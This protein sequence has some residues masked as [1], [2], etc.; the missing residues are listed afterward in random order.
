MISWF[1]SAQLV[2][3][4]LQGADRNDGQDWVQAVAA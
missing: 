3:E 4:W 1:N 2:S